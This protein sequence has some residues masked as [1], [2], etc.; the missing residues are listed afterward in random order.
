MSKIWKT[1]LHKVEKVKLGYVETLAEF[2]D[3][4]AAK[5][6]ENIYNFPWDK[7]EPQGLT[8][9][10]HYSPTSVTTIRTT[11][12][13]TRDKSGKATPIDRI[14]IIAPESSSPKTYKNP[15]ELDW[16]PFHTPK[17]KTLAD[18]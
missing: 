11:E 3:K 13:K 17:I 12:V 1:V 9:Y 18:F 16:Q 7:F 4:K 6:A 2:T 8:S 10:K 15:E 5:N 14:L